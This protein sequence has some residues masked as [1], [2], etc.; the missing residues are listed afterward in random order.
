MNG[1]EHLNLLNKE[2]CFNDPIKYHI[3]TK[4]SGP[5]W[6][7][8]TQYWV[9]SDNGSLGPYNKRTEAEDGLKMIKGSSLCFYDRPGA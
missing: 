4:I 7:R 2:K 6:W 9:A 3:E 1:L 5:W 8:Q